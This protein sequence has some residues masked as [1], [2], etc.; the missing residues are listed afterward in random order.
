[1][2]VSNF[3]ALNQP[4]ELRSFEQEKQILITKN[5]IKFGKSLYQFRNVTG[6]KVGDI[7]KKSFPFSAVF[8]CFIVAFLLTSF[9][10]NF[11]AF[12]FWGLIAFLV[13][14]HFTQ[15]QYYGLTIYLNSGHQ[16]IFV[17]SDQQFLNR[18]VD[19][20]YNFMRQVQEGSVFVDFS[21][22]SINVEGDLTGS[23]ST[24]NYSPINPD[25]KF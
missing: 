21:N 6:F 1:M 4:D 11:L 20:L 15:T 23:A 14:R 19:T 7:P 9:N 10:Q 25:N 5:V 12:I 16:R 3:F 17:S 22:K 24:G 18:V 13:Y 8:A 2:D